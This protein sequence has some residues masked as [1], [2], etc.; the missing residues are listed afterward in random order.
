MISENNIKTIYKFYLTGRP[1]D[2]VEY[3]SEEFNKEYMEYDVM[4]NTFADVDFVK[5][6]K[7]V[8]WLMI[9]KSTFK[10]KGRREAEENWEV[11]ISN[12]KMYNE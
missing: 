2:A 6:E 3:N 4:Y 12:F 9:Y 11:Y 10:L 7:R 1:E 5:R 8:D